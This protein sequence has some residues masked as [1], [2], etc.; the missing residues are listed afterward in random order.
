LLAIL[1]VRPRGDA[2][3]ELGAC[4]PGPSPL[5][6]IMLNAGYRVRDRDTFMSSDPSLLDPH[7]HLPNAGI[8]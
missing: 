8:L 5:L 4:V 2:Q 6:P 7:R 1:R 3:G